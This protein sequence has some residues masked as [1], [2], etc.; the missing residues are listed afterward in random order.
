M[1]LV[2]A[3]LIAVSLSFGAYRSPSSEGII[4]K[5]RSHK[6]EGALTPIIIYEVCL[7]NVV[8][9]VLVKGYKAGLTVKVKDVNGTM[10]VYA[11]KFKDGR[12]REH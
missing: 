7:D 12:W 2:L 9:F 3:I 5:I 4:G 11:C 1:K 10:G 6:I 8:Y